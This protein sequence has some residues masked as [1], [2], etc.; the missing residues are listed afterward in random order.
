MTAE[1]D[2]KRDE[3]G[4]F[5]AGNIAN[6]GGRPKRL[7]WKDAIE[8]A[9]GRNPT[10]EPNFERTEAI[11]EALVIAAMAGDMQAIKEIGDRLDGKAVQRIGGEE[12]GKPIHVFAV[13]LGQPSEDEWQQSYNPQQPTVQ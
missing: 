1:S 8:V 6:P 4:R 13:P 10:G 2:A 3:L 5:G 7:R 12:E 11:A 9:L